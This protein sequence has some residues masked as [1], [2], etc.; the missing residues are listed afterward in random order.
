MGV[1]VGIDVGG[2]TTKIMGFR[3]EGGEKKA[4][5]PL[6]VRANDPVTSV[7]GAFG[8][9]T[10]ENSLSLRDIDKVLMTGVGATFVTT[11]T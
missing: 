6:F 5:A 7:Y 11:A 9:F 1:V 3:E 8:K 4:L 10:H 2:S